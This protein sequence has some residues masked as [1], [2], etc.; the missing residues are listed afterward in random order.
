[1]NYCGSKTR[2]GGRLGGGSP[3]PRAVHGREN[4]DF[5]NQCEVTMSPSKE[6]EE[7]EERSLL[8]RN[9]RASSVSLAAVDRVKL[10]HQL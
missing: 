10:H 7:A 4:S 5:D 9:R 3:H 2:G 8:S 1:M 6:M